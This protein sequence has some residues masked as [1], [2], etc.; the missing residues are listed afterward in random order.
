MTIGRAMDV[1]YSALMKNRTW[2]LVPAH[3]AQNL[4]DCK[5]VFKVKHNSDGSIDQYKARL[6]TKVFKQRYDDTFIPMVKIAIVRI[7]LSIAVTRNWCLQQLDVQNA[8]L[9]V[10]LEEDM[11]MK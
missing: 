6:V 11:Y 3:H 7:I 1:E 4:V 9:H 2:H 5:W 8:F 10:I